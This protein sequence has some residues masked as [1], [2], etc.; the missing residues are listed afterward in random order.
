MILKAQVRIL[1]HVKN[2]GFLMNQSGEWRL[3][4]AFDV[5]YSYNPVGEWTA[6]HQMHLNGKRDRFDREDF[7]AFG[8]MAGLK[9]SRLN[10]MIDRLLSTVQQWP[11]FAGQAGVFAHHMT[12]IQSQ[13]RLAGFSG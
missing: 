2:I 10:Q 9:K 8:R 1:T 4:P 11:Y 7:L 12:G 13:L 6:Q 5:V 3:S